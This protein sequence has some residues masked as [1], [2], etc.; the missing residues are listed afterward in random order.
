MTPKN[1]TDQRLMDA[2]IAVDYNMD[3]LMKMDIVGEYDGKRR[4]VQGKLQYFGIYV[5]KAKTEKEAVER[6]TKEELVDMISEAIGVEVG[7]LVKANKGD[8]ENLLEFLIK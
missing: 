2:Y 8:L 1:E 3:A 5:P 4:R 7:T 6:V